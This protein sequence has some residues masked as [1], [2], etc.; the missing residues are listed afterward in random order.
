[1]SLEG[2]FRLPTTTK[3][4]TQKQMT[5]FT[6]IVLCVSGVFIVVFGVLVDVL[7][8][9][10]MKLSSIIMF[11]FSC[12]FGIIGMYFGKDI[13]SKKTEIKSND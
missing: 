2:N 10:I 12:W 11:I 3:I 13:F 9:R 6:L 7:A 8:D 1:M 5:W 4:E